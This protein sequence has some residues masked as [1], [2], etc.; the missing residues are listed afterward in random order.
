MVSRVLS[1]E[2]HPSCLTGD[3]TPS[4]LIDSARVIPRLKEV[5]P[6]NMKFLVMLRD[7]VK[8]AISHY[9]MVTSAEGTEAQLQSRGREWRSKTFQEVVIDDLTKMR[10]CGLLPYLKFH[11]KPGDEKRPEFWST[12]AF[13]EEMFNAFSGSAG[14][15]EAWSMYLCKNVPMKTGSY[16]LVTRGMYELNLRPWLRAFDPNDFLVLK[17]EGLQKDVSKDGIAKVWEHLGVPPIDMVADS[18]PK[19]SRDYDPMLAS[20]DVRAFLHKFYC[21]HTSRLIAVL[22]TKNTVSPQFIENQWENHKDWCSWNAK[23][24]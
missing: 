4:Y 9:A 16:G 6:H 10:D 18:S 11:Y 22:Q 5:F 19:N 15:D 12:I 21:F 17:L 1:Q 8:R 24:D 2:W 14:E 3:S 7:P 13:D 23:S 20:A